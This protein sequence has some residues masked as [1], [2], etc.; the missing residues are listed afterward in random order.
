MDNSEKQKSEN[1]EKHQ[2]IQKQIRNAGEEHGKFRK[3]QNIQ[4]KH[5]IRNS[6]KKSENSRNMF[7]KSEKSENQ[8]TYIDFKSVLIVI[9]VF[10]WLTRNFCFLTKTD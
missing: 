2:K 10:G 3:T 4:E 1:S 9:V 5:K 6:S 7:R 8:K